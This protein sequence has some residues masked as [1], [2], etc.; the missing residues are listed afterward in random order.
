MLSDGHFLALR[1]KRVK[2]NNPPY[3]AYC[4]YCEGLKK[5]NLR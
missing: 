4:V 1:N 3:H 2:R 5:G